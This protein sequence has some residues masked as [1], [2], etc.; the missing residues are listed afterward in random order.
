[1]G[2]KETPGAA[3]GDVV[4][5]RLEQLL[6]EP[7]ASGYAPGRDAGRRAAHE[8]DPTDDAGVLDAS[9]DVADGGLATDSEEQWLPDLA[10]APTP[11]RRAVSLPR[12]SEAGRR[13][14]AFGRQHLV[15]VVIIAL[16]GCLW[17]G[18]SMTQARTLP[19]AVASSAA[20][21]ASVVPSAS[22]TPL[23]QVHVLGAVKSPGV[24]R[25]PQGSRVADAIAAAGGLTEQARPGEL[26]L[27]ALVADGSQILIGTA[28][29]PGGQ[30]RG[31]GESSGSGAA[32]G[33]TGAAASGLINLN[34]ATAAQL[35]TLP[36][37]GPVTA[38]AILAWRAKHGRFSRVEELQEVDGIGTKTYAQLAPKVTV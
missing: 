26:N 2:V 25:L 20:P 31:A 36:G 3:V 28:S 15:V 9:G 16:A 12:A 38:E 21:T 1:M 37:V 18:F 23:L 13:A 19:L 8:R 33:G 22:P 34:T 6:G 10:V 11:A 7:A 5:R 35:D 30:V 14:L 29:S 27:A 4:R 24:V 17:A 32:G